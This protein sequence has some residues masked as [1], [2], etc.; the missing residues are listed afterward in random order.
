MTI[1]P[2]RLT[3]RAFPLPVRLV[4]AV[5]LTTV[6]FG[7]GSALVQVHFQDSRGGQLLPTGDDMVRKFHGD[8]TKLIS[9]LERLLRTPDHDDVPF[10][11]QGSMFRAF[12]DRSE[13]WKG[14]LKDRTEADV[15]GER[16]GERDAILAWLKS[17]PNRA[18][19]DADKFSRP[20]DAEKQ[21]VTKDFLNDDGSVKIKALLAE[22]CASC[23]RKE[24]SRDSKAANFPLETFDQIKAYAKAD[25]GAMSL[26]ALAQS[27]HTHLL[28]FAV[29]FC[30]TGLT[31]AL[32]SYPLWLRVTVAPMVL[33]AQVL[34]ISCW[35]LGRLDGDVGV[36]CA[37]LVL[38]FGG[39]VG[40]GLMVQIVLGLF[41]LFG[42][43]GKAVLVVLMF[44]AGFGVYVLKQ[45][46]IEPQL[47][48]ESAVHV[49]RNVN[50]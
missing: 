19:H 1:S 20:H 35:W 6:G 43:V 46:V 14:A 39:F 9:P 2:D 44:A 32:S 16:T 4:L 17:G 37:R 48:R 24:D 5:F 45:Q 27:T 22:R 50:A 11:G 25:S 23:H 26:A 12:T 28:A 47:Q 40:I 3:L 18:D 21:P 8:P 31:F 30:V 15:V 7:Y 34:E 42:A 41:D 13:G 29:L 33:T 10:T 36:T 38:V 49:S